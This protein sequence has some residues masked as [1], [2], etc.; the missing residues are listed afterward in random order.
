MN[1]ETLGRVLVDTELT[2]D[3]ENLAGLSAAIGSRTGGSTATLLPFFGPTLAGQDSVTGP[4]G[5]DLRRT[6]QGGQSY[7]WHR[8]FRP[9]ETVRVIIDVE[10]IV[11][12]QN[13]DLV[14]VRAVFRD[15]DGELIQRQR[16]VFVQRHDTVEEESA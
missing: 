1:R 3:P 11:E 8:P 9:G 10:D 4:L 15:S 13:L 6:L 5:L 14:T 7:E 2:V 16:T 12:K